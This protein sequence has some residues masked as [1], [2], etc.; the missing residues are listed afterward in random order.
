MGLELGIWLGFLF[1]FCFREDLQ[2]FA[3]RLFLNAKDISDNEYLKYI[4]AGTFF[5]GAA[6]ALLGITFYIDYLRQKLPLVLLA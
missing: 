1:E 3:W 2:Q 5:Y 6:G 4:L